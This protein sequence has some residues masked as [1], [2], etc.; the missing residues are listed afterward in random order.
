MATGRASSG[1]FSFTAPAASSRTRAASLGCTSSTRSPA[2]TSSRASRC[3]RPA[4]PS[5]AQVRAGHRAAH[6]GSRCAC[7]AGA[8]TRTS[9]GTTSSPPTATAVREPS[10]GSAP[11]I[12]TATTCSFLTVPA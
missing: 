7:A 9:P 3:P 2:A 1:S 12:T 10:C 8:R 5:T 4:A 11:I 6:S